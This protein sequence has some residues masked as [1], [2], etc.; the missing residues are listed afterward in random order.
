MW[1]MCH[2]EQDKAELGRDF[3]M[4]MKMWTEIIFRLTPILIVIFFTKEIA[5]IVIVVDP[6]VTIETVEHV[7]LLVIVFH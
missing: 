6:H 5:V 3:G 2:S 4:R 1:D 7:V